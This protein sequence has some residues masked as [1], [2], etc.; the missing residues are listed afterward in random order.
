MTTVE[1][2][3]NNKTIPKDCEHWKEGES[4]TIGN[5][6]YSR[7]FTITKISS[8]RIYVK[9]EYS[10]STFKG[11][12]TEIC[13]F[14]ISKTYIRNYIA[15]KFGWENMDEQI[16]MTSMFE[17]YFRNEDDKQHSVNWVYYHF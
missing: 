8:F 13:D 14:Y 6:H 9:R 2:Q 7:M 5:A 15:N 4:W 3:E 17:N 12:N 10:Y 11:Y 16:A 1:R